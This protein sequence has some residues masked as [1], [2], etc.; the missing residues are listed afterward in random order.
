MTQPEGFEST[1][2]VDAHLSPAIAKWLIE[3]FNVKA[4]SLQS[5]GLRD[6]DDLTIFKE[7]R[8]ASAILLTKD[9]DLTKI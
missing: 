6:V 5:L 9:I 4:A 3:D 1:I 7:T 8:T 2:W